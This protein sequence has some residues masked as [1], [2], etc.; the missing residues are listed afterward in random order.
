MFSWGNNQFSM[1][2]NESPVTVVSM[3]K[4]GPCT[5]SRDTPQKTLN[6]K[7][8]WCSICA[9]GCSVPQIRTLCTFTLPLIWNVASLQKI[10]LSMKSFSSVFNCIS[11]QKSRLFTL[12]AGV[13]ACTNHILYGLK[14]SR[15][16]NTFHTVIYGTSNSLLALATDLRGLRRTPHTLFQCCHQTHEVDQDS[17]LYTSIQFPQTVGTIYL[18]YSCMVRLF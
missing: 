16:R 3:K 6:L 12:S 18:C 7:S 5:F 10:S 15:L 8:Q 17:C 1:S 4:N 13:R 2:R 14:H 11:S 9:C